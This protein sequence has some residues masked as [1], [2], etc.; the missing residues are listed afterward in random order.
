[1]R[2]FVPIALVGLLSFGISFAAVK[3]VPKGEKNI[4]RF[5]RAPSEHSVL[6]HGSSKITMPNTRNAGYFTL[7]DS[8]SN[9]YGMVS[10]ATRPLFVDPENTGYWFSSYRQFYQELGSHGQLGGAFS[11][12]G[13]IGKYILI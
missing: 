13:E 9:G 11:E 5:E 12:D 8:A 7:V 6:G 2:K 4:H 10:A 3:K 1:M